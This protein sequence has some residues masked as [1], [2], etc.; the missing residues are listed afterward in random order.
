M[1][2]S[3]AISAT[4]AHHG[5]HRA[6]ARPV[7]GEIMAATAAQRR[8][9]PAT[10][11]VD[12]D[13]EEVRPAGPAPAGVA[14]PVVPDV[15]APGG[16]EMLRKAAARSMRREPARGGPF[17]WAGGVAV[18]LA[19]FWISG[20]HALVRDSGLLAG[21]QAAKAAFSVTGVNSRFDVSGPK[22]VLLV[23][24]EAANEGSEAGV[25]PPL[26]IRVEAPDGSVT[27]Y[28][29]GTSGRLLGPGQRFAF[30]SRLDVPKNGVGAVSVTFTQ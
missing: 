23:D 27:R 5:A 11:V 15:S 24:G 14:Q 9:G 26:E 6:T 4:M 28:T 7:S 29:L 25:L 16:M 22:Q 20:G 10:D 13:Y 2:Q 8:G 30:S 3:G 17:F 12:A 1:E 19:A 21:T 18:A